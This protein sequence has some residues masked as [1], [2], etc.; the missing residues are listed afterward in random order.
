MTNS[1]TSESLIGQTG[2]RISLND[3]IKNSSM[4]NEEKGF[5]LSPESTTVPEYGGNLKFDIFK[6]R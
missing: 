3:L 1:I 6:K 5:D 2:E 4:L